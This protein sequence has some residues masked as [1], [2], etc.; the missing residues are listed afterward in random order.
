MF[1]VADVE[2]SFDR[3]TRERGAAY[4]AARRILKLDVD[5]GGARIF[6]RVRGSQPEPYDVVVRVGELR[7]ARV[8]SLCS[9]PVGFNCKHGAA[10]AME[11]LPSFAG[12]AGA[13]ARDAADGAVDS[14]M[15]RLAAFDAEPV[16]RAGTQVRYVLKLREIFYVPRVE[17][18]AYAATVL[19]DGTVTSSRALELGSL[20]TL[21]GK[22]VTP[23]DRAIA[24]LAAAGAARG[25]I[26]APAPAVLGALLDLAVETG[27]LH[28][29][30]L[31]EPPLQLQPLGSARLTWQSG[32]D[33]RQR[34]ALE[35]MPGLVLLAAKPVWYVDAHLH[36]AGPVEL[37]LPP[38]LAAIAA[39]SPA[40]TQ[41]QAQRVQ[42][43]WRRAVAP[44]LAAAP[45]APESAAFVDDE[46]AI[47]L[48]LDAAHGFAYAQLR[49]VYGSRAVAAEEP[50]EEFL[51]GEGAARRRWR[52]RRD[53]ES[54]A[55]ERLLDLGLM[56]VGWPW[57]QQDA[58]FTGAF[59]FAQ[60]DDVRWA[61]LLHTELDRLRAQGW[62]VDVAPDFPIALSASEPEWDAGID[63]PDNRWFELELGIT[64]EGE[65]ISL[66]PVLVEAMRTRAFEPGARAEPVY[67]RLPSSGR[68]V[69][70]DPARLN[71][72][73]DTL[74]ELFDGRALEADGRL[75]LPRARAGLLDA[76]ERD[77]ALAWRGRTEFRELRERLR[78]PEAATQVALPPEFQGELRPYQHGG[79]AWL[80]TLARSGFGAVLAD[81]MGLGKTVQLLA[82]AAMERAAGRLTEPAL[83]VA[84]TSVV[85]NWQAEIAR[86]TP[87]LRTLAL[88]GADREPKFARIGSADI[89]LT[90]YALLQRDA[91]ALLPRTW[92]LAVLDEAQA[93]KNPRSKG[94]QAVR[95]LHARQ[96][97]ALTGT[98]VENHLDELWSIF[99]FAVPEL[100]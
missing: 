51:V 30:A 69:V 15:E 67:A 78:A 92:S 16:A 83:I 56:L 27:R 63:A 32:N 24:R 4:R 97:I 84:P 99:A 39:A 100:L 58:R 76:I 71:R 36:R 82:H 6:A 87:H 74:V 49:F 43:V 20:G 29:D 40:L 95:R 37:G 47:A 98:P 13:P 59:R 85:P 44:A 2:A 38:E 25:S 33:G 66:L 45:A 21:G 26:A 28:F 7:G 60:G 12:V 41:R 42:Q 90:T 50:A 89:V 94:A 91:E 61:Q 23:A 22:Y 53:V 72:I 17:I 9:C 80:Q 86:F 1:S 93:V 64:V 18:E 70:L 8:S 46:P 88:T 34:P 65:R 11:A 3:A 5:P 68:Y 73:L 48:R 77:V 79:V 31:E 75:R 35:G 52:R 54:R 81:D 14:W 96:R 19:R 10:V 62:R 55:Q 57:N